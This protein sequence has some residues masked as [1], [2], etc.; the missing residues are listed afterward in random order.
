M[1]T[2]SSHFIT[3][4]TDSVGAMYLCVLNLSRQ[5]RYKR[6]NMILVGIIPGPHEPSLSINP[7]LTPIVR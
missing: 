1:W 2:G 4:V 3:H 7:Y 5:E 6:E